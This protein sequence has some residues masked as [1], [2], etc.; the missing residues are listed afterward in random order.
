MQMKYTEEKLN[1]FSKVT[2]IQLFLTQQEQLSEIDGKLQLVLEQLALMNQNRFGRKTEQMPV[3]EQLAFT[4]VDGELVLFNEA[5]VL[6][7]LDEREKETTVKKR[8][9]KKKGKRE[10]DL[11]GIPVVK[12]EHYLTEKELE[13]LFG[14]AGWKQLPD[15]IYKR[16]RFIPA[17][18][19]V[20][21][22]HVGVYTSKEGDTMK[23][24]PHPACLLRG[25]LVSPSL[26]AAVLN[27]KYINAVPFARLEKEFGRYG[28]A[29][30]RQN[31]ANWTIECADRYLAIFYDYLHKYIYKS[32]VIHADETPVLVRKDGREAGS[33]SYMW[34][35]RT[36]EK[37]KKAVILYEYQ[38]TRK[39]DHP[40][41]F[42]KDYKGICVTDG[43]QVYHKLGEE[44]EGLTIAG[45]WA[46]A[47]RRYDEAV[48]ALPSKSRKSSIAWQALEQIQM[49]YHVDNALKELKPEE[50]KKR[51]QS[52]VKP[53]VE[54]YFAW[55]KEKKADGRVSEKSKTGRGLSY[56]INQEK[57]LKV[58]LED[59]NVPMDNNAAERAIK[60]FCIG[61]KNWLIIDTIRGAQSSAI[62]YSIAETAKAN[63][64]KPYEYFEYLLEE[65][66]QHM[67][68][69]DLSFC[70]NL[71]PWST[72]LPE[73]CRKSEKK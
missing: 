11:S 58:F 73:K 36:G 57:Y 27:G 15:E 28:L 5:E 35:Y 8:P 41:R 42:L 46:H 67:E 1:T 56:S 61:R 16:Y 14:K 48:K 18:V 29:I 60:N 59:G 47:R 10:E 23:K 66:S 49:I 13:D 54:A 32:P 52:S 6:A 68:D 4:D 71:L 20:E 25:S 39:A 21:E 19:E 22:H 44:K 7:A 3:P 65:I 51:R 12:V 45:C 24:A 63:N 69:T 37:E 17:K 26:E 34:V 2:L 53:L 70:E 9:V 62:I 64:L 50:R 72:S 30:T 38:K 33:K 43:Y 40:E 31:M 55:V